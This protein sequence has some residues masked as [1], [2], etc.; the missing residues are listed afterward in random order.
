MAEKQTY[1]IIESGSKQFMVQEGERVR[2]PSL[3]AKKGD[4]LQIKDVLFLRAGDKVQV[5]KPLVSGAA[6]EA[7]VVGN[8][9]GKKVV[10][11]KFK[12]R[13]NVRVKKGHRQGYTEVVI[14]AIKG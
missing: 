6:V 13:K 14:K 11:F 7:E 1:A 8:G 10:S 9:R 12:R 5:G 3:K 2:L 4:K